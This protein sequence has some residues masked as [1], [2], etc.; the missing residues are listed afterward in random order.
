MHR[1]G[2][3]LDVRDPAKR[4]DEIGAFG[5]PAHGW[6]WRGE[7]LPPLAEL[8]AEHDGLVAALRAEGVEVAVLDD[9]A[10]ERMKSCYTRDSV[11][12]VKG[13]AVVTRLGPKIRRGEERP[14]TQTLARL[15]MP[16]LR[17]VHGR[18]LMEGGSFVWLDSRTAVVGLSTRV[19]DEGARQLEE[20]LRP[21]GVELLRAHL[22]GYRLHIDGM[23]VMVDVATAIVNP[24]HLPFWLIERLAE[25]GLRTVEVC[26]EDGPG[27]VNCLAVRPGRVL[28]EA[29]VSMRTKDRLDRL[30]IEIVEVPYAAM[31]LGGGGIHCSTAPLIRDDVD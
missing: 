31:H 4:L 11:I 22:T 24:V 17:T 29:G 6:Y 7:R 27:T 2:A 16:I 8:Q 13:G 21:Q 3:E 20:V 5:D 26:P 12:A 23:L 9:V 30:G 15:G 19:N 1:P 25:T 28:M 18:G 10:P 14:V